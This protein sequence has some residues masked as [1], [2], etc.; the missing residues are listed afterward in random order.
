MALTKRAV[1]GGSGGIGSPR[2]APLAGE[3]L[4]GLHH[5]HLRLSPSYP[6]SYNQAPSFEVMPPEMQEARRGGQAS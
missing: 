2:T 4:Q 3:D 5:T 1:Q 6:R